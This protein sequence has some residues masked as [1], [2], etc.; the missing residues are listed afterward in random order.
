MSTT[1]TK[2]R[3]ELDGY[4]RSATEILNRVEREQRGLTDAERQT[5]EEITSTILLQGGSTRGTAEVLRLPEDE[6]R[7]VATG[8]QLD[9]RCLI[10]GRGRGF[11]RH[12]L[13]PPPDVRSHNKHM[14]GVRR[15]CRLGR[16]KEEA[17]WL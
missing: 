9:L 16:L 17:A 3:R 14:F 1:L 10:C 8:I 7:K 5:V 6:V 15:P 13:S 4:K 12:T 11:T 2:L